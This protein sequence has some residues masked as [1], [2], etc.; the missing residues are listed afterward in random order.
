MT[1]IPKRVGRPRKPPPPDAAVDPGLAA[2]QALAARIA[3]LMQQTGRDVKTVARNGGIGE[4][5][6]YYVLRAAKEPGLNMLLRIARGLGK[7]LAD[8][9][10]DVEGMRPRQATTV[11]IDIKGGAGDG[12]WTSMAFEDEPSHGVTA[13]VEPQDARYRGFPQRAIEIINDHLM[14]LDPPIRRGEI[15]LYAD[16]TAADIALESGRIY[17]VHRY[18]DKG[19]RETA[20]RRLTVYGGERY[21]FELLSPDPVRN[22]REKITMTAAELKGSET[23]AVSGMLIAVAAVRYV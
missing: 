17:L 18:D 15:A 12:V 6:V 3:E 10:P 8:L 11:P 1:R 5:S 7:S 23:L 19:R 16:L 14:G 20:F 21:E 2:R 4:Q 13:G 9:D 22:A